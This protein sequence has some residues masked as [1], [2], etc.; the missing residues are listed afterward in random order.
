[1]SRD[2]IYGTG[3]VG[4]VEKVEQ[5]GDVLWLVMGKVDGAGHTFLGL[6]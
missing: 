6:S 2:V 3:V 1:M 5:S 4:R